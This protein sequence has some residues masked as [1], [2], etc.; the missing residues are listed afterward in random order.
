V[1]LSLLVDQK[2]AR[3]IQAEAPHV[4][5][6][7]KA[8]DAEK[9]T[10]TLEDNGAEKTFAV[11]RDAKVEID[12]KRGTLAEVPPGAR[13]TLGRVD[14]KTAAVAT[15]ADITIDGKRGKLAGVP[16]GAWVAL[17]MSADQKTVR[18][19]QA[20]GPGW[21]GVFVKAV[22]AGK[23]TITFDDKAPT[24]LAGKTFPVA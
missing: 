4:S 6:V 10:V 24:E 16:P 12:G 8:V 2:T 21:T 1:T 7:A 9:N 15:D 5:G 19:M 23:D 17:G 20:Y 22:D 18:G 14:R 11:T 13:V 3:S